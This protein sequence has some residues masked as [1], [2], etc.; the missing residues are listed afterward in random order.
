MAFNLK[1]MFADETEHIEDYT[2]DIEVVGDDRDLEGDA[3]TLEESSSFEKTIVRVYEPVS[4]SISTIIIDALKKGEMCIINFSKIG[5][6]ETRMLVSTLKGS[7]YTMDGEMQ[8]IGDRIIVCAPKNFLIDSSS[9][10][11]RLD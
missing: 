3:F 9:S 5:D 8:K 11:E 7:V 6:E 4:S 2:S 1:G 10:T